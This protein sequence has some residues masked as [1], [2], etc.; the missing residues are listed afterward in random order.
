MT[1]VYE[2]C[3]VFES[4]EYLM[5]LSSPEAVIAIGSIATL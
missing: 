3:P 2:S 4:G 5:R 1:D